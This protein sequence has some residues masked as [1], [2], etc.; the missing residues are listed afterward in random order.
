MVLVAELKIKVS[1]ITHH[2]QV[3]K[4]IKLKIK[5]KK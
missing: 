3:F 4:R 5:M 1:P 2:L